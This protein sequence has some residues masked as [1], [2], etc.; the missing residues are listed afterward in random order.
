MSKKG[1]FTCMHCQKLVRKNPRIKQGQKYCGA[2]SCQAARKNEWEKNRL[3]KDP[4]YREKR[5]QVKKRWYNEKAG[6]EYQSAYRKSHA[7][8][9]QTNRDKQ[10]KRNKNN[11]L[12]SVC[13]H[14]VKTDT[15]SAKTLS[16]KDLYVLIPHRG[17]K[18]VKTDALIVQILSPGEFQGVFT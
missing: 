5:K 3:R 8:Y 1:H 10:V 16:G 7:D 4:A 15:L 6:H 14:I 17:E 11:D 12:S 18:I 9:C 2:K 13:T